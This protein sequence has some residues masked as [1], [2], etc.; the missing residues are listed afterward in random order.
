MSAT[1][2]SKVVSI[3]Y[4]A[5]LAILSFNILTFFEIALYRVLATPTDYISPLLFMT[6]LIMLQTAI[7]IGSIVYLKEEYF[8]NLQE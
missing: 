6:G 5:T 2:L 1:G 4:F 8:K 3:I 7:V